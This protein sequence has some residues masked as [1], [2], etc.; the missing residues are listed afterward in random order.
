MAKKLNSRNFHEPF[1]ENWF[2]ISVYGPENGVI[3]AGQDIFIPWIDYRDLLSL[4][5]PLEKERPLKLER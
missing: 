5:I 1:L 2:F 3:S 4:L